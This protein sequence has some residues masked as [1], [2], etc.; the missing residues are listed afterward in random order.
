LDPWK[1]AFTLTTVAAVVGLLLASSWGA[2]AILLAGLVTLVLAGVVDIDQAVAGFANEGMITVAALFLV[3]AGVRQTGAMSRLAQ[4]LLGRSQNPRVV[5]ARLTLPVAALSAFLNNTP[6]V[7][8]LLPAVTEW[9][10][11]NGHPASRYLIPL[12]YAT[13]LGG[14]VTL[15]GTST[16]LVVSGLMI[17]ALDANPELANSGLRPL[18]LFEIAPVG[19]PLVVAGCAA[20]IVAGPWLLPDRRA[21]LNGVDPRLYTI[22]LRVAATSAL[23]GSTIEAA[24]LRHLP[25]AYLGEIVRGTTRLTAVEPSERLEANDRLIFFGPLEAA[26]DLQ[27]IP[28][29]IASPRD[30][31]PTPQALV[32][33]VVAPANPLVGRS[34]REGGFRAQFQAVVVAVARDG[35]R[36][37]GRIGDIV[38][39]AGDVL[40]LDAP[41][42]W[43]E[44]QRNRRDFYLVSVVED[45]ARFRHDRAWVALTILA[46]MVAAAATEWT[47]MLVASVTAAAL[48]VLT[49]CLSGPEAR[50]S[51]EWG[52]LVAIAAALGIGEAIRASGA[53]T[54]LADG[55]SWFGAG[56]PV[57]ALV[58]I[59]IGTALLTEMVTNN[60]A[61]ALMFPFAL[62][63]SAELGV[64]PMP[65]CVAVLFA[66]SASFA[67][68]IGYQ[69]NLMVYGPGGYRFSDFLRAGIPL[70][71]IAAA[72]S[73]ALIPWFFPF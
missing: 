37:G 73:L 11:Q 25:G 65:Y 59:Y 44:N 16:N 24:G 50:R 41:A 49:G 42:S 23:V 68:P 18:G 19:I 34:V 5:L 33:A 27:R 63:L 28:G 26:V 29:L 31:A 71:I 52:V 36:I 56:S 54:L 9:A 51:L 45:S 6:I 4:I 43:A 7:A 22:E 47:S 70:Q 48:M 35:E 2:D 46:L 53:D 58:A 55:V 17:R 10:R 32:E 39:Q 13:I 30:V 69:T 57:A 62:S 64:S 38:L 66:A 72:V 3:A 8:A 21:V 14:T 60:A 20:L 12:S 61:A 1:A 67:T 15:I 40:L